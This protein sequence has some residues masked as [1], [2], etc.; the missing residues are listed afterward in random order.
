MLRAAPAGRKARRGWSASSG[1]S[2]GWRPELA[3]LGSLGGHGRTS[4][5]ATAPLVGQA[6]WWLLCTRGSAEPFRRFASAAGSGRAGHRD[7]RIAPAR[8]FAPAE[9]AEVL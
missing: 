2:G 6:G 9:T 1:R 7:S 5:E 4:S 8:R 3:R